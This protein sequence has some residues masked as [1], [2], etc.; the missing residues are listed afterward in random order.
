M[1]MVSGSSLI[2]QTIRG[3]KPPYF[4]TFGSRA[5]FLTISGTLSISCEKLPLPKS[6]VSRA[7]VSRLQLTCPWNFSPA[8]RHILGT[9][10][11]KRVENR[12]KMSAVDQR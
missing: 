9:S 4:A 3:E 1:A 8:L 5:T 2:E 7:R 6:N 12:R 11:S 10:T